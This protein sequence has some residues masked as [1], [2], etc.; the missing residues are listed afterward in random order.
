MIFIYEIDMKLILVTT[1]NFFVEENI[2][3]NT[4]FD[5]GLDVLHLRKPDSEPILCEMLL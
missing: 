5:E 2:I 1:D 3:I 4:L